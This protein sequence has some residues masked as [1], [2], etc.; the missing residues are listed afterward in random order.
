M[1]FWMLTYQCANSW[2]DGFKASSCFD[3]GSAAHSIAA[4]SWRH[5]NYQTYL[6]NSTKSGS[7]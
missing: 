7:R 2:L 4:R 5:F 6:G 3:H 1:I